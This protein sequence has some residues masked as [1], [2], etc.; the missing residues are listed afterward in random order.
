MS[1]DNW[2]QLR[3]ISVSIEKLSVVQNVFINLPVQNLPS[4]VQFFTRLGFRFHAGISDESAAC[5]MVSPNVNVMLLTKEKFGQNTPLPVADARLSSEV[6]VC[7]QLDSRKAVDRMIKDAIQAGGVTFKVPQ[8]YG[9]MYGHSFQD[10]DGHIW[11]LIH[12]DIDV[13]KPESK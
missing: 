1:R 4:S 5:M 9:F 7:L 10:L 12:L 13:E 3:C 6:Q 8:D 11:E 2:L